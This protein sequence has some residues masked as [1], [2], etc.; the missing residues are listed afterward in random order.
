MPR[1]VP[2]TTQT[3]PA[4]TSTRMPRRQ[5]SRRPPTTTTLSVVDARGITSIASVWL[6]RRRRNPLRL[7]L[8]RWASRASRDVQKA[9]SS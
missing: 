2:S 4:P 7:L 1:L 8:T 3:P 6:V 9:N 5:P